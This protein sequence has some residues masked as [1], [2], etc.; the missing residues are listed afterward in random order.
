MLK[1]PAVRWLILGLTGALVAGSAALGQQKYRLRDV[2]TPGD[3]CTVDSSTDMS[4][5]MTV[6]VPGSGQGDQQLPFTERQRQSY[7]EKVLAV[8]QKGRSTIRRTY[9]IARSVTTDP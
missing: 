1:H 7:R 9:T 5:M 3:V 2:S 4:L 8:D 6:N